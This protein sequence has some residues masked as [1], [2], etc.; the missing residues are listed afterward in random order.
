MNVRFQDTSVFGV[1]ILRLGLAASAISCNQNRSNLVSGAAVGILVAAS[2]AP[3]AGLVG[4]A[5]AI[6]RW[7]MV[8]SGLFVL[9]LQLVG[10]NLN[11]SH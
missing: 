5:I 8:T 7:D 2:L 10:I 9:L 4:M 11:L 1:I 3:P 6:S